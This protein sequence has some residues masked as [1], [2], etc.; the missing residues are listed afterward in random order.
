MTKTRM[1]ME[2]DMFVRPAIIAAA[3]AFSASAPAHAED[4]TNSVI[5]P[6]GDLNLTNAAD[7]DEMHDRVRS[8]AFK[9]C[10]FSD[11]RMN[12]AEVQIA[13]VRN[14]MATTKPQMNQAIASANI[15]SRNPATLA[16]VSFK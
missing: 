8:A 14:A 9:M 16:L 1:N 2:I 15:K 3:L 12:P 4:K 11:G 10:M 6:I 13:C 5:V 7:Q